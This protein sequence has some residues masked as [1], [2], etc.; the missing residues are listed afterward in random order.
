MT[1]L[2]QLQEA[3]ERGMRRGEMEVDAAEDERF[4]GPRGQAAAGV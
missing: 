4:G 1:T 3:I 2:M